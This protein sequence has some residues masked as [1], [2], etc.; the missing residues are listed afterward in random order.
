[1]RQQK[2]IRYLHPI[3]IMVCF[4]YDDPSHMIK[5]CLKKIDATR[6]ARKKLENIENNT[7]SSRNANA[8]IYEL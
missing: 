2:I 7:G 3:V 8:V 5:K 1:M 4:N 6:A